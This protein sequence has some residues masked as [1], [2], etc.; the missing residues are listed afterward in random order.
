MGHRHRTA[1]AA[2]AAVLIAGTARGATEILADEDIPRLRWAAGELRAALE[3]AGHAVVARP[4]A[5]LESPVNDT[6]ALRVVVAAGTGDTVRVA[7][8]LALAPPKAGTPQA[9]SIRRVATPKGTVLAVLGADPTGAMYGMLDLAEA[10]GH[11]RLDLLGDSD[12][13]PFI[14][15]RGLKFNIPLDVRTP[16][17]S[18]CGD[19]A[20]ANIPEVWNVDFW[21]SF[22]DGM[23]RHRFNTL[24]LWNLHPFPSIVKVPGFL[25]VALDDVWR[26]R[27]PLDTS[28][29]F[30]GTDMVRPAMLANVEVV[31]RMT[32]DEKIRFWRYVMDMADA[33][34]IEVYWFTW[35]LFTWGATGKHGITGEQDDPVTLAYMRACVR[36]TVTTY[37]R[38]AG[39]GFTA[40]ENLQ[41]FAGGRSKEAW[42]QRTYGEGVRDA[43]RAQPGR[44][45]RLIHRAHQSGVDGIRWAWREYDGPLDLSFKYAVAH[46]HSITN[47]P[48]ILPLLPKLGPDL[49]TWLTV[50]NDDIYS[51]RW[52]DPDYAR[53][54][55]RAMP[56]PDKCAGFYMGPDGTV[57]GRD[58][59][60]H[61][62]AGA[63]PLFIMKHW[64]SFMLWGRLAYDPDLPEDR[65]LDEIRRRFP[66][67]PAGDL[68]RAWTLASR[69]FPTITSFFWGDIDLRWFPEA[70]LSHPRHKGFY[71]VRH[72]MEGSTMPGSGC[73]DIRRWCLA[74]RDGRDPGGRTPVEIAGSLRSNAETVLGLL[75]ALHVAAGTVRDA[76][77]ARTLLD[78]LAM[79]RLGQYYAEKIEGA[80]ALAAFDLTSEPG[81]RELAVRHLGAARDA[82]AAYAAAYT[83]QY[84]QP[85][86][87]NRVGVVDIPA[88]ASKVEADTNIALTWRPGTLA[89]PARQGSP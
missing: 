84:R 27:A 7:A 82:W 76:E 71:T 77:L 50:R 65:F 4:P 18:D 13:A 56:G 51:F 42:L 47:P 3:S 38:L 35:N 69:V 25:D 34:G 2:L 32:I 49:R 14:E 39:L 57:W 81:A 5:D 45:V 26:T 20:Q 37:P 87:Y 55:L 70:C 24:T 88:L 60:L 74:V 58:I 41:P 43:L 28:F 33:R 53:G 31:K 15:R 75:P 9:Y 23:A 1:V 79:A 85:V 63:P 16:S 73:V 46:M 8:A 54:F 67:I 64:M 86:L 59:L 11:R 89:W 72:F 61:P 21:R 68:F 83:Q 80:A 66:G 48:F 19:A 6:G 12:H 10:A 52:A 44:S 30:N 40:G 17:Y 78:L 29:S 62:E 36:E 22:L